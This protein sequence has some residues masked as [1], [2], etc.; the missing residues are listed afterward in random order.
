VPNPPTVV[1]TARSIADLTEADTATVTI[2][3]TATNLNNAK[4]NGQ[5]AFLF[6]GFNRAGAMSVV[7]SF[8]ADGNGNLI[9]GNA[10][11][12][13]VGGTRTN[14]GLA[15]STYSVGPDNSGT[16][17]LNTA[18]NFPAGSF[19]FT[20]ALAL[21]SFSLQGVAVGGRLI[22]AD[23]TN[24][25]GTGFL[26]KQDPT[27]FSTAGLSGGFAFGLAG[28]QGIYENVALGRFSASGGSL[29]DGIST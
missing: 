16:M 3:Y 8:T 24:Q 22:E 28:P 27:A 11:I 2:T 26:V 6:S 12:A 29:T 4:F 7:G 18:V 21:D 14:Q 9:V 5:Y 15:Q 17:R 23:S 19:S 1:V 13:I 25:T 10:D 20:F